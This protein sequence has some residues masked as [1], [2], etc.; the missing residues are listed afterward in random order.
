MTEPDAST[1]WSQ[2]TYHF[3]GQRP[4]EHVM[5]VRNKHPITLALSVGVVAAS[6]GVPYW[7]WRYAVGPIQ[8]IALSVYGVWLVYYVAKHWYSYAS[9]V[10]VLTDQ[11]IVSVIQRGFFSRVIS[12]AELSRI[13]DVSSDI[14][15]V[16]ETMF[17]Y[18]DVTIRTA[19]KDSL[20]VLRQ[21]A[22]PYEVQQ[23]IVRALKEAGVE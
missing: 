20:L 21:V 2:D 12:E 6:L 23:A 19:S 4:E 5:L 17:G 15:G 9:S 7:L 16:P 3:R 14:K 13:Q 8:T 10:A 11:R 18:G 22:D 1:I